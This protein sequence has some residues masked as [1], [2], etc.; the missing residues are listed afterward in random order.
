M[1]GVRVDDAGSVGR[2]MNLSEHDAWGQR[3]HLDVPRLGVHVLYRLEE[4]HLAGIVGRV[5]DP[6]AVRICAGQKAHGGSRQMVVPCL[7]Q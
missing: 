4:R 2:P 3:E 6:G 7:A 1:R 5:V